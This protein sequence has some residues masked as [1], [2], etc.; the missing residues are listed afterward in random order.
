MELFQKVYD[1]IDE[2]DSLT[3]DTTHGF[4]SLPL[5]FFPVMRYAKELKHINIEHVFYGLFQYGQDFAPVVDLR[6]YDQILDYSGAA[7]L[8]IRSG[9]AEEM[10]KLIEDTSLEM[11]PSERITMS[12]AV[13]VVKNMQSLTTALLTCQGGNTKS[14]SI[15]PLV[16]TTLKNCPKLEKVIAPQSKLFMDLIRHA[17]DS[18]KPFEYYSDPVAFSMYT[19]RWYLER[20]LIVQG[21]TA[22]REAIITFLCCTYTPEENYLKRKFR[23]ETLERAL[24]CC[25]SNGNETASLDKACN[26]PRRSASWITNVP[27]AS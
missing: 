1:S 19:V 22:L 5:L 12:G 6:L 26:V 16:S 11:D 7:H 24:G 3:V 4:R 17:V 23:V 9:N 10:K 21:Y 18:I 14:R 27:A 13:N 20:G 8:F 15:Q 25:I 2:G